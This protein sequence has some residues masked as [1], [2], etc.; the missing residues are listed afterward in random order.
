MTLLLRDPRRLIKPRYV[1]LTFM[2]LRA[3]VAPVLRTG[4]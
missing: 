2:F 3:Q 1:L 4:L